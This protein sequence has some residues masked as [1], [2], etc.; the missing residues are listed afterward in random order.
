M[1]ALGVRELTATSRR[2]DHPA[3][4]ADLPDLDVPTDDVVAGLDAERTSR[5]LA[6]SA[7]R[8]ASAGDLSAHQS[9]HVSV[10]PPWI[11]NC[12]P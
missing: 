9:T 5:C 2:A 1:N 4:L 11:T 10:I 3:L 12:R 6:P 7:S 8:P